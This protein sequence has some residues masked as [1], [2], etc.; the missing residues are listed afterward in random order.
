MS[1]DNFYTKEECPQCHITFVAGYD[2]DKRRSCP[3]CQ[4]SFIS[5]QRLNHGNGCSIC[6]IRYRGDN[7]VYFR[8]GCPALMSSGKFIT[9]YNSTHELT[10]AMRRLNGFR[11]SNQFRTFML[12]NGDIFMNAERDYQLRNNTCSP[13]IAC[14]EGWY[15]LWTKANGNWAKKFS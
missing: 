6:N 1:Q 7:N 5:G 11:S 2:K 10:E 9:Y 8:E 3:S 12:N 4:Y 13:N 14:S 15:D